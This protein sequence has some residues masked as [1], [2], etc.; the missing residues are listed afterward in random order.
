MLSDAK[1]R[2]AKP[3]EKPYKLTDEKGLYVLAHPNGSKYW[4]LKYR[5][6]GN[7]KT[8]ALGVYPDVGLKDAR[9]RRD[10]ARRLIAN[11]IDPGEHKKAT[12]AMKANLA[13]NSFEAIAREWLSKMA[14]AWAPTHFSK[15]VLRLEND[16]FPWIGSKP[17]TEITA[18]VLLAMARRVENRGAIDTAHRVLQNCGQIFRYAIATG[19]AERNPVPDLRGA[20]TAVEGK[21]FPSITDPMK[22]AELLR[23]IDGF[24]GTLPVQ[25]ALRLAPLVFVRPG[26][27]RQAQWKDVDLDRGLWSFYVTKTKTDHAVPL[28]RQAVEILKEVYPLTG[29]GQYVFPGGWDHAKPMSPAA[30]AA[31]LRRLGFDT[32]T[33]ITGHGFRA[34]ARTILHE[35]L[36]FDPAVIEHQLAHRVSDSLGS[37]YNRTKFLDDRVKMMQAWADYLDKLKAGA[38]VIVLSA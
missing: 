31:A 32:K 35:R 28:C 15:I 37:A 33:E 38:D 29:H 20:L 6:L 9:E 36:K 19:R 17:I 27:L 30:I 25:C 21:H 24:C 4:R 7:E 5:F 12:K 11:G 14:P 3:Q 13:T 18:P 26:E 23:A 10:E 1:I 16:A 34:M 2:N 8:L 22:V